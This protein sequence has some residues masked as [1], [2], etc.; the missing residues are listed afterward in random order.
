MNFFNVLDLIP[1]LLAAW[2]LDNDGASL[3]PLKN[4]ILNKGSFYPCSPKCLAG[5]RVKRAC[6]GSLMSVFCKPENMGKS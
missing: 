6:W 5:S 4:Q 3:S 1:F 2:E